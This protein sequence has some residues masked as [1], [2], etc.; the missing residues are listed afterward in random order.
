[1]INTPDCG[2]NGQNFTAKQLQDAIQPAINGIHSVLITVEAQP[3]SPTRVLSNPFEV[4]VPA[5]N[6]FG[7]K[8]CGTTP[9]LPLAPG[10]Y[11]PTV[12]GGDYVSLPPLTQG[13]HTIHFHG[14]SDSNAFG[15]ITQ[16][17]TYN[18]TIVPVSLK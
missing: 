10:V 4:A 17:V 14:E 6:L 11:S 9:P 18:L 3:V 13:A 5:D 8:A 2:Q 7:R 1:N 16:D 15:H 12:D